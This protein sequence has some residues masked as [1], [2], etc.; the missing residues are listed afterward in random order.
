ML[1]LLPLFLL[2]FSRIAPDGVLRGRSYRLKS[3]ELNCEVFGD[4][5]TMPAS[6]RMRFAVCT[7]QCAMWCS[8]TAYS[9][10]LTWYRFWWLKVRAL[11]YNKDWAELD[12]FALSKRSPIGYEVKKKLAL[13]TESDT[14]RLLVYMATQH[15][16][17]SIC[18]NSR[19]SK[20]AYRREP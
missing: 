19:S 3:L 16:P 11:V 13:T 15:S 4:H 18:S 9:R 14:G 1:L 8:R 7:T 12:R 6:S 20:N 10:L 17:W 2:C 5:A